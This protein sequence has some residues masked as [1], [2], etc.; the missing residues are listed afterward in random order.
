V[1]VAVS[2]DE[3]ATWHDAQL[4]AYG[5]NGAWRRWE[6]E[7]TVPHG[8]SD[9]VTLV[10]RATDDRGRTQPER[11]EWNAGGYLWNGWDRITLRM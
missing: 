9:A 8:T 7:M 6:A 11:A 4:A 2:A 5:G 3:G 10:A 1:A